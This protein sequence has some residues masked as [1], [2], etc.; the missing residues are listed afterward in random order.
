MEID[1]IMNFICAIPAGFEM[2]SKLIK[3][4]SQ[5]TGILPCFLSKKRDKEEAI[6]FLIDQKKKDPSIPDEAIAYEITKIRENFTRYENQCSIVEKTISE[7]NKQN[8][9]D[10]V[11]TNWLSLFMDAAGH[12]SDQDIQKLWAKLLATE[13][14]DPGSI[15]KTLIHTL[16][17]LSP[18]LART[19]EAICSYT[20]LR[21]VESPIPVIDFKMLKEKIPFPYIEELQ[22]HGLIFFDAITGYVN[23]V[24]ILTLYVSN[25]QDYA[26]QLTPQNPSQKHVPIGNVRFT[27]DGA[28]LYSLLSVSLVNDIDNYMTA[29][30]KIHR[31]N[32]KRI[33]SRN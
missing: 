27:E 14:N 15:P 20:F 10:A 1:T 16:S 8:D 13:C 18:K 25:T 17:F 5:G 4:I 6:Q 33:I 23:E 31:L 21:A 24:S 29:F 22:R 11:D 32:I 2:A 19:F 3:K 28:K 26:Y 12:I 7:L 30:C 9:P